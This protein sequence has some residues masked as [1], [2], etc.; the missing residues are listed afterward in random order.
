MLSLG[1]KMVSAFNG[2]ADSESAITG[3][4]DGELV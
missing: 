4:E 2:K 3:K 1:R